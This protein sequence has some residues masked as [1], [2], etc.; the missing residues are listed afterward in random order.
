[1]T[2]RKEMKIITQ[3][4]VTE[5]SHRISDFT[6]DERSHTEI[7]VS[8]GYG[9]EYDGTIYT[10]DSDDEFTKKLLKFIEQHLKDKNLENHVQRY[11]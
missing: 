6:P 1:M 4:A 5:I 11:I 8:S 7:T 3:K 2:G 10:F 9:S